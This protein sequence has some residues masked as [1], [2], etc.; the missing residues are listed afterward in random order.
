MAAVRPG[1]W[2][3]GG[4][5]IRVVMLAVRWPGADMRATDE[6]SDSESPYQ[7]VTAAARPPAFNFS[8][9]TCD[10]RRHGAAAG[11]RP[12]KPTAASSRPAATAGGDRR[13]T[14]TDAAA[15]SRLS[16]AAAGRRPPPCSRRPPAAGIRVIPVRVKV[17]VRGVSSVV[18]FWCGAGSGRMGRVQ[19]AAPIWGGGP[20]CAPARWWAGRGEYRRI[21]EHRRA[22]A[23]RRVIYQGGA[24]PWAGGCPSPASAVALLLGCVTLGL[25]RA[26]EGGG[27][28]KGEGKGRMRERERER[29]R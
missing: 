20:W 11:R 9:V 26:A 6:P 5:A 7:P 21:G 25:N 19:G 18:G 22:G 29:E 2:A 15:G 4:G 14:P 12:L 13:P 27:E 17:G 10:R 8:A 28:A 3:V 23:A 16:A 24:L 1:P